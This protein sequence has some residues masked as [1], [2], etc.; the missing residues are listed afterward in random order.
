MRLCSLSRNV[1]TKLKRLLDEKECFSNC[2][3]KNSCFFLSESCLHCSLKFL[4]ASL[5]SEEPDIRHFFSAFRR[6]VLKAL[7]SPSNQ[8]ADFRSFICFVKSGA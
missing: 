8:G 7:Y 5:S 2:E 1:S 6:H 4:N 3:R